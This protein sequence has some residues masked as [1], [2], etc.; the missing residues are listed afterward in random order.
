MSIA[1]LVVTAIIAL[2]D[3][4]EASRNIGTE[5]DISPVQLLT[6]TFL[7]TPKLIEQTIPFV[8]LFGVMGALAGMNKRS[9]LTSACRNRLSDYRRALVNGFQ[10][11]R[12][13][14]NG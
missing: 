3:Y 13:K 9:E 6:L 7:K 14:T 12:L 2:V 11:Y 8:V 10:P 5:A 1:L 4:V